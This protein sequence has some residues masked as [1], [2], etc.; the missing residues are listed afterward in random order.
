MSW[1]PDGSFH[2]KQHNVHL[3]SQADVMSLA[4]KLK[5]MNA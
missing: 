3:E 5:E 1:L 2:G 4:D